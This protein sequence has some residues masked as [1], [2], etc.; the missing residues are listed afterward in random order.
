METWH[1]LKSWPLFFEE[2]LLGVKNFEFRLNDRNYHVGDFLLLKEWNSKMEQYTGRKVTRRI[3][4]IFR[5]FFGLPENMV[6]LG[7]EKV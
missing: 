4:Y 5:G 3:T 6:I 1:E 7:L 2:T